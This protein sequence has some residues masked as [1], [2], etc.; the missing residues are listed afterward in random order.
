MTPNE[1]IDWESAATHNG[2]PVQKGKIYHFLYRAVSLSQRYFEKDLELS[3]VGHALS[4]DGIHFSQRELFITPEYSWEEFGC[5]DPRVTRFGD[6]YYIFYTALAGYPP[7]PPEIKIGLTITKDFKKIEEKHLVTPFNSKAMALFP[8]TINGKIAAILTANTDVPPAKI[9]LAFFK[10]EK[11]IWSEKY[12]QKWF[13]QLD[14]YT[15][16]LQRQPVDHLEVGAPPLK[17]EYGWLLIYS[18]IKNYFAPP[19]VF[20]IEAVLLDENN[21]TQI[22]GRTNGPLMIPKEEYE[23]YGRVPNVI[24][25]SGA[26]IKDEDLYLYYGAADTTCCLAK[27]KLAQLLKEIAPEKK[28]V[29][30]V[31]ESPKIKLER[32]AQNPIIQPN[33]EHDWESEQTFNP[34]AIY[35]GGKVHL[36][37]RAEGKEKTSVLGYASTADGFKINERL[38]KPVY[39]PRKIF[40][41]KAKMGESGCEDPR[42]SKIGETLYLFYTAYDGLNATRIALSSISIEDFLHH[43]WRWAEPITISSPERNDKNGSLVPEKIDSKYW[44]FHRIGGC[45]WIDAVTDLSFK[46]RWVGGKIL[47]FPRPGKWDSEK[48]GITG[49]PIKTED[50]WLLV[51]HGL[52]REDRKYR[53]GALLLDLENPAKVLKQLAYPILEPEKDYENNGLRPGTVFACGAVVINGQLFVYYGGGDKVVAVASADLKEILKE[54]KNSGLKP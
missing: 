16:P 36:L 31:K 17:T 39:L 20:G 15:L 23:L 44:V 18:Y 22:I 40:E 3:S 48:V 43:E 38:D 49:S 13:P 41:Q 34:T 19:P 25:P 54:I 28:V 10:E 35:A 21:P 8:Q 46:D 45:I 50:G 33:P 37:Y 29:F 1:E 2:C 42:I 9:A 11:E 52:S 30:L 47:L 12:W 27:L 32:Y 7:S 24:F 53:L 4:K 26:L 51:Y 6:K 14:K 5:E